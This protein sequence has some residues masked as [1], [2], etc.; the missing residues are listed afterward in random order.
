MP[1]VHK[2]GS[3]KIDVY[4]NDHLPP[5]FHA[6]YQDHEILVEIRTLETYAGS[7]PPRQYREVIDWAS[8]EGIQV[9]L[10]AMYKRFNPR[11]YR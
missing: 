1:T 8:Q 2:I 3:V 10:E 9:K 5:H 4:P 7:L 6:L 11:H